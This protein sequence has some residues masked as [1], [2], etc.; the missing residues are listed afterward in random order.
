LIRFNS[1]RD[2]AGAGD[3]KPP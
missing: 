1:Y 3:K 2:H